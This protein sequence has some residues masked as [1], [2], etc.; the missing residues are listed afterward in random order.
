MKSLLEQEVIE[1]TALFRADPDWAD[2]RTLARRQGL[3][4]EAA[5]LL[6]FFESED[7]REFGVF[8]TQDGRLFQYERETCAG[9]T[10]FVLW[11]A[12]EGADVAGLAGT[13]PAV[14]AGAALIVRRDPA[15]FPLHP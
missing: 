9:A 15:I 2:L 13:F 7:E 3:E 10:G 5:V 4:P 12:V 1:L 14:E 6:G 11:Q 8:G